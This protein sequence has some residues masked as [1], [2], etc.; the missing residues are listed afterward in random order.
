VVED[1]SALGG[2]VTKS[3]TR[4]PRR[5]NTPPRIFETASGML[6]S[7]GIMNPGLDAFLREG[8][9]RFRTLPCARIVN[10]AGEDE[11]DFAEMTG[12]LS[13]A[14]GCDAIELNVSCPNVSGGLDFG[15]DPLRLKALV[16]RCRAATSLPLIVKLTPNVTDL[17]P[18]AKA[19]TAAGAD[20]L[21]LVNTYQGLAVDWRRR[22]PE[23][24]SP[25]G[26]GGLSG[27]AIKPLALAAVH[28]VGTAVAIPV[29]GIGGIASGPDVLEFLVA[30]A[31]AVQV[32]TANFWGPGTALR[33]ARE[34]AELLE[35]EGVA[36]VRDLVGTLRIPRGETG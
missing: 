8:L 6:N 14:G 30:G 1:L 33:I 7:I 35:A 27:P 21:S 17:A 9:P 24:G 23:L 34:V 36:R 22:V 10:I 19:A 29:I 2:V 4:R 15:Q 20:A 25:T 16:A 12:A 11:G 28:R 31:S 13:R 32:G 5:G 26:L 3:V 18:L